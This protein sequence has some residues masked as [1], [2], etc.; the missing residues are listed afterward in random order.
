MSHMWKLNEFHLW[1]LNIS[2][3]WGVNMSHL[4]E[5]R[6]LTRS[7]V[8]KTVATVCPGPG[9]GVGEGSGSPRGR[10]GACWVGGLPQGEA[11]RLM[12]TLGHSE[13]GRR[14][15]CV[16]LAWLCGR[17]YWC[18][19]ALALADT[20]WGRHSRASRCASRM[21]SAVIFEATES[22]VAATLSRCSPRSRAAARF[23]HLCAVV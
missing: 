1:K 6:C 7:G 2:H 20:P 3:L 19:S 12:G 15:G 21:A 17:S 18:W 11:S 4:W 14:T 8:G 5:P 23:S 16:P 22:R 13:V 9:S 10:H